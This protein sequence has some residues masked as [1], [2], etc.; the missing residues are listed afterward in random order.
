M[1]DRNATLIALEKN[2]WLVYLVASIPVIVFAANTYL[3]TYEGTSY[4]I[5]GDLIGPFGFF[6]GAVGLL[7]LYPALAERRPTLARGAA[8]LA[9]IPVV[10]WGLIIAQ[11][12]GELLGVW[13]EW[14]SPF[15]VIPPVTLVTM[16]LAF[17]VFSALVLSTGSHSWFVGGFLLLE[18]A[19]FV[20]LI[21]GLISYVMVDV[22]HLVAFLG[23]GIS[24]RITDSPS[25]RTGPAP[26][27]TA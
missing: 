2:A 17:A 22:G 25:G 15:V 3:T 21:G 23:L 1:T 4:A 13:G 27:S 10:L 8:G 26:D 18:S 5:I 11:G 6:L 20:A 14:T 16:L 24:L 7:G 12:I 9:V 19:M